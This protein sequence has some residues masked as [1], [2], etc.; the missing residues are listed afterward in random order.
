MDR[1]TDKTGLTAIRDEID[2]LDGQM[3][4][5]LLARA[6]LVEDVARSKADAS[7][8]MALRP[9]REIQQMQA[10]ADWHASE[11]PPFSLS[12]LL[13]VWR[14]IIGAALVQQGGLIV[15]ICAAT[16]RMARDHFGVAAQYQTHDSATD[17]VRA[18][19]SDPSSVAVIPLATNFTPAGAAGVFARLPILE[20]PNALCYGSVSFKPSETT[21][22]LVRAPVTQAHVVEGG[23]I[24]AKYGQNAL[25]EIDSSL[26]EPLRNPL[27]ADEIADRYGAAVVWLGNYGLLHIP[28]GQEKLS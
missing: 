17:A 16:A 21:V 11:K 7:E 23:A 9:A 6:R 19:D 2:A 3:R 20:R 18:C 5:L 28:D 10:L 25:I 15:H 26:I 1:N 4:A 8:T 24:M 13:A 22:T 12:T 14:E 27:R